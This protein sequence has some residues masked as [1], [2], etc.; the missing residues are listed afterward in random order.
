MKRSILVILLI[1]VA[2][3]CSAAAQAPQGGGGQGRGGGGGQGR[4]GGGGRGAGA[5]AAPAPLMD[6]ANKIVDAVNK[7]DAAAL[8]KMVAPDAVYLDED[9]HA[10]PVPAWIGKLTMGTSA[11]MMTMSGS[12]GQ[13][14]DDTGWFSFNYTL[15]ETFNGKPANLKGTASFVVKKAASGD[16]LLQ[17]IHGALEQHVAGL[18]Q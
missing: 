9:G 5:P 6:I 14:W 17:V 11:K 10:L 2:L 13:L 7:Q 3:T 18:T 4:G 8:T 16:W 15:A 1:I 12:H